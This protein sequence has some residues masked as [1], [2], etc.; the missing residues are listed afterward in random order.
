MIVFYSWQSDLPSNRTFIE[1]CL[2]SAIKQINEEWQVVDADRSGH[3]NGI[4]KV[5]LD[6]DT[7]GVLGTPEIAATIFKKIEASDLFVA[8]VSFVSNG[9]NG[10]LLPNPNVLI[11]LGYAFGKLGEEKII[12]IMDEAAGR[13]QDLPFDLMHRRWPV[14]FSSKN[15]KKE[16]GDALTKNLFGIL[17][18]YAQQKK[19]ATAEQV[20]IEV[21]IIYQ[22]QDF[23]AHPEKLDRGFYFEVCC[24]NRT[25]I[26]LEKYEVQV[27]LPPGVVLPH[28]QEAKI[29][30]ELSTPHS[31]VME[32]AS[33][34]KS[35]LPMLMPGKEQCIGRIRG[36]ISEHNLKERDSVLA[37]NMEV[38]LFGDGISSQKKSYKMTEL[39]PYRLLDIA[40]EELREFNRNY[41]LAKA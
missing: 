30:H 40:Y 12:Q 5:Q 17:K 18:N 22:K 6:S 10:K 31:I 16:E 28:S 26:A 8:D 20:D 29:L 41:E 33:S 7:R 35:Q 24:L 14:R 36:H 2:K 3:P 34:K 27:I 15:S 37:Q 19:N 11:E 39:D 25:L 1:K 38:K 21:K 32:F 9:M 23:N 13:P 4:T